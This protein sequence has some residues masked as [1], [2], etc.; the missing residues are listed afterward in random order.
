VSFPASE[1]NPSR[2]HRIRVCEPTA[3]LHPPEHLCRLSGAALASCRS[4]CLGLVCCC[5]V[6]N[7]SGSFARLELWVAVPG[8][9]AGWHARAGS[10]LDRVGPRRVLGPSAAVTCLRVGRVRDRG[11]APLQPPMAVL[12]VLLSD[13]VSEP[14]VSSALR[15]MWPLLLRSD[16]LPA[17]K[18]V[19][20]LF[21]L[22]VVAGPAAA[23]VGSCRFPP[24]RGCG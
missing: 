3:V 7:G 9:G 24:G 4:G 19:A 11:R 13:R 17:A 21:E 22:P 2:Q 10:L 16:L 8:S 5:W 15:A 6:Q 18:R 12:A 1:P 23:G 20:M 14:Q